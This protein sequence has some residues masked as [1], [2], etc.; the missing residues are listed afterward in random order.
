MKGKKF[1]LDVHASLAINEL[2]R[3]IESEDGT[4]YHEQVLMLDGKQ[5]GGK[6]EST[7]NITKDDQAHSSTQTV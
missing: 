4:R 2:K 3:M 5:L 7:I 1:P 6:K